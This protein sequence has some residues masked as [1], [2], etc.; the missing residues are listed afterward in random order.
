MLL[1]CAI[2]VNLM[3]LMYAALESSV[4]A[5]GTKGVTIILILVIAFSLIYLALA[6]IGDIRLQCKARTRR[7]Q[8]RTA[9]AR[10]EARTKSKKGQLTAADVKKAAYESASGRQR[11]STQLQANPMFADNP[12]GVARD[13]DTEENTKMAARRGILTQADA[14]DEASWRV[15]KGQFADL[16]TEQETVARDLNAQRIALRR[17]METL[18]V[19]TSE[20]LMSSLV[21]LSAISGRRKPAADGGPAGS[22]RTRTGFRPMLSADDDS[23]VMDS[24]SSSPGVAS[25][26]AAVSARAARGSI[27]MGGGG[28]AGAASAAAAAAAA[29]S[30]ATSAGLKGYASTGG[31]ARMRVPRR[32]H[33]TM[34]PVGAGSGGAADFAAAAAAAASSPGYYGGDGEP[35][36]VELTSTGAGAS[37]SPTARLTRP[38]RR[39]SV[40]ARSADSARSRTGSEY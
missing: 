37:E 29:A 34:G 1:F 38:S 35:G 40:S 21:K 2:L 32:S 26:A 5:T 31:M 15:F 17:V 9:E 22:P 25:P 19:H 23:A 14:P 6:L 8:E 33:A 20:E 30:G 27:A 10:A 12:R 13:G 7:I 4:F 39:R 16:V 3:A 36:D 18:N 11:R 28:G 24:M